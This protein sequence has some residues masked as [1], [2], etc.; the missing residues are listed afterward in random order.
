MTQGGDAVS[1]LNIPA[2]RGFPLR[3]RLIT[4]LEEHAATRGV[5]L[6]VDNDAKAL[7]L[8]EGWVGA[9]KG[10]RDYLAMVVSTGIGGGIVLDGR[11]LG[12]ASGNAG[13][14]GHMI[15]EPDGRLCACGARGC[16]EAEASGTGIAQATGAPPWR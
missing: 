13:H 3:Q 14:I 16:L 7:A 1:P 9:A 15:V 10:E 5:R 8:G 2:W 12:G 6:R 11:L 4:V